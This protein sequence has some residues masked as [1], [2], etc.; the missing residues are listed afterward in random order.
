MVSSRRLERWG[1]LPIIMSDS[2]YNI[3]LMKKENFAYLVDPN[4][5]I[6]ISELI[7]H[8]SENYSETYKKTKLAHELVLKKYNWN[9]EGKKLIQLYFHL[10]KK[11]DRR[12]S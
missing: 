2:K 4:N 12:N 3:Q 5:E 7:K 10:L 1:E 8:I 11:Y 6:A 9:S